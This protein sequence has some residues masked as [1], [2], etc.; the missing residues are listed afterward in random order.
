MNQLLLKSTRYK[1]ICNYLGDGLYAIDT[2]DEGMPLKF[3]PDDMPHPEP[4]FGW[5]EYENDRFNEAYPS[6]VNFWQRV[7]NLAKRTRKLE[8][9]R[10]TNPQ[11]CN[12][13]PYN[14]CKYIRKNCQ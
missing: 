6:C 11:F 12:K 5:D 9:V 7:L 13:S 10:K 8:E 4:C 14:L 2:H 3:Y 1:D